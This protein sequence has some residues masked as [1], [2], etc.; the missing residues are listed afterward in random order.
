MLHK[1]CRTKMVLKHN[2]L[3]QNWRVGAVTSN[4][5]STSRRRCSLLYYFVT[6]ECSTVLCMCT[7]LTT[8]SLT[9]WLLQRYMALD[10]SSWAAEAWRNSTST[11]ISFLFS[12]KCAITRLLV[13]PYEWST[14]KYFG[15]ILFVFGC[16]YVIT[17]WSAVLSKAAAYNLMYSSCTH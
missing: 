15:L 9:R 4:R 13:F 16:T 6:L 14:F 11:L 17:D 7:T 5:K 8:R 2:Q 12:V 10:Q 3:K 1:L